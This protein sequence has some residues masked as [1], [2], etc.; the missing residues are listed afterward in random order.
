MDEQILTVT[1]LDSIE[2]YPENKIARFRSLIDLGLDPSKEYE[3]SLHE[4]S[5]VRSWFNFSRTGDYWMAYY[6][7]D[8]NNDR[9][10]IEPNFYSQQQ[11]YRV[12]DA[13]NSWYDNNFVSHRHL[14][15]ATLLWDPRAHV[16]ELRFVESPETADRRRNKNFIWWDR[17]RLSADLAKMTGFLHPDSEEPYRELAWTNQ[18]REQSFRSEFPVPWEPFDYV[19]LQSSLIRPA[20]NIG[21]DRAS[22]L[23]VIP[24]DGLREIS[25]G[26]RI[27]YM[28]RRELW[29]PMNSQERAP[30]FVFQQPSGKTV[31]FEFGT[32]TCTL[33]IREKRSPAAAA[34]SCCPC[35]T[36]PALRRQDANTA[37]S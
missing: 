2:A 16:F 7:P 32:A 9:L 24:L 5:L 29:F 6:D 23:C 26:T 27:S 35:P 12:I 11:F 14:R 37:T 3:C 13:H 22:L 30:E 18:R 10:D 36:R 28:P 21:A 8:G 20:H 31:P 4:V 17:V 34:D 19:Y 15:Q 33:R 25:Y 1:S